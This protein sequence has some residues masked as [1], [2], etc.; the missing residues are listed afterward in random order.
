MVNREKLTEHSLTLPRLSEHHIPRDNLVRWLHDR[1]SPQ[2]KVIVVQGA[3]GGGKTTLLAEFVYKYPEHCF[4]FFVGSDLWAS[5]SRYFLLEMCSQMHQVVGSGT[6]DI[7]DNLTDDELKQLFQ[8]FYRRA[9]KTARKASRPFYFVVDGLDWIAEGYGKESILDLLP[10]SLPDGIYLLASSTPGFRIPIQHHTESI[11]FFSPGD[12]EKYLND[13]GL[14]ETQIQQVYKACDGMPGYLAQIRREVESGMSLTKVLEDLPRGFRHLLDRQWKRTSSS[15]PAAVDGLSILSFTDMTL[16][17]DQLSH[18]VEADMEELRNDLVGLNILKIESDGCIYFV[19]DAH[20][21]FVSEKLGS[22]RE[23]AEEKLIGFFEEDIYS[24]SALAYLPLLYRKAER[25][26]TLKHLVNVEYMTR[27]LKQRQDVDLLRRNARLVADAA[28]QTSDGQGLLEYSLVGSLLKTLST[29]SA[30]EAE[31]EALLALGEHQQSLEMAYEATLPEDR[32][33]LLARIG[34]HLEQ[35]GQKIPEQVL[36]DLE[37]MVAE[38]RPTDVLRE[39]L[40]GIAA[41]LFYI[42]PSG[43]LD[44]VEKVA[45][46]TEGKQM[47]MILAAL[48]FQLKDEVDSAGVITHVRDQRLREFLSVSSP[49][50]ADLSPQ[51]VLLEAEKISDTSGKLFL[52]RSWCNENRENP[53]AIDVIREALEIM[54]GSTNYSPSMRHLRQFA[55]PLIACRG[56]EVRLVIER[57]DLL[58]E[59]AIERPAEEYIRLEL[60]LA[61]VEALGDD[62]EATSRLYKAYFELDDITDLDTLCNC[63]AR[64]L[65][66]LPAIAPSDDLLRQEVETRLVEEYHSL[67]GGAAQHWAVVRRL[68]A[69]ITNYRPELAVDFA[70]RL[71]T[72]ERRDQALSEV[73]R[74][75]IDR[76]PYDIDLSFI[77]SVLPRISETEQRDWTLLRIFERFSQRDMFANVPQSI[78]FH[79]KIAAMHSPKDKCY[80]YAYASQ[81][82]ASADK[83]KMNESIFSKMMEE[84]NHIDPS[85]EQARIGFDVVAILAKLTPSLARTTLERTRQLCADT[86]LADSQCAG[87]Y[88]GMTHLIIRSYKDILKHKDYMDYREKLETAI[89]L[90]PSCAVQCRLFASLALSHFLCG[91]EQEFRQ[92]MEENTLKLLDACQDPEARAQTIVYVAPSLF[93]Y[94]R[95]LLMDEVSCLSLSLRD[96]A[97]AR[98]A[99][100]L[101]TESLLDDPV[102]LDS[103]KSVEVEYVDALRVC[104]VI[105]NMAQDQPT[106]LFIDRLVDV[107]IKE[108][109]QGQE[110]GK[111]QE[112]QALSIAKHLHRVVRSR[113]PDP[114]N[115]QHEGYRVASEAAIARL[116]SA[117]SR[118][119][120]AH[121]AKKQWEEVAPSWE[122][123]VQESRGIPNT[124]DKVLVMA[125]VGERAYPSVPELGHDLLE[126]ANQLIDQVPN[127]IDRANRLHAVAEAWESVDDKNSARTLLEQAMYVLQAWQWDETRDQVTGQILELA[128][129]LDPEFAASLTSSV[130]NPIVRYSLEQDLTVQD[131]RERPEE[132]ATTAMVERAKP[133]SLDKTLGNAAWRLVESFCCG[134]G[135]A[136]SD[137]VINRWV[138]LAI[139]MEFGDAYK[140]AALAIENALARNKKRQSPALLEMY[141]GLLDSLELLHFVGKILLSADEK[142]GRVP[143]R[144]PA[145]PPDV[146]L[147]SSGSQAE[148][149]AFLHEWLAENVE[150]YVRIYDA[151]FTESDLHILRHIPPDARVDIFSL[152]KT[153]KTKVGDR[154]IEERY[155]EKWREVSDISPS[156]ETHFHIIGIPSSGDGPIHGR[157]IITRGGGVFLDPSIEGVGRK[158]T[159]VHI[160]SAEEAASI[161]KEFIEPL[162]L[163]HYRYWENERIVIYTFTIR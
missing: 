6:G 37:H 155:L 5:S 3:D 141:R 39:R 56:N 127:A 9:A 139:D 108:I 134:R 41:N 145:L 120:Y 154:Q 132:V 95:K 22:Q 27:T 53:A 149:G 144:S 32:L 153:H 125:W 34:S 81:M 152:W 1:F 94:E 124:A 64:V 87:L 42:Y 38:I 117:G 151:Y 21:R 62:D 142:L 28:F 71:N 133:A 72:T 65:L 54:T 156:L 89:R 130:D 47:D 82:L 122:E 118:G 116:R 161:E 143:G 78:R 99:T 12:T 43:A 107:L 68:I 74:V 23:R 19:T 146:V 103:V 52:L 105:E 40:I 10:T 112:K 128:H 15:S 84:W 51:A 60:L 90:V 148:A 66:N 17:I 162:L 96:K 85:W 2:R 163:G 160:L 137:E 70:S 59:T 126:E 75:Y 121:R 159:H 35:R 101:L 150:S 20:K 114:M 104:E 7:D 63:L 46:V 79:E 67:L 8:T 25:H 119:R 98:V 138:K 93:R 61:S 18:I 30:A 157:Y 73:L 29:R 131:L 100:H 86:P 24:D 26:D 91:R 4:S 44:L 76:E 80:A 16:T 111:L 158:D 57:L 110:I 36:S 113:F 106:Y 58:K 123:I 115:I 45:G 109:S 129:S 13:L 140:V 48:S 49:V 11:P 77:E 31:I 135:Y 136:Q 102:G 14:D 97:L 147:F 83:D 69:A 88:I 33:Q 50:V 55:E 92:L